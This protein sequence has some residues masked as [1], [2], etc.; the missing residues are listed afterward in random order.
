MCVWNC[1]KNYLKMS[2]KTIQFDPQNSFILRI[3]EKI[4]LYLSPVTL[5]VVIVLIT[6]IV[7]YN[8]RRARMVKLINKIPGPPSLP[9]VGKYRKKCGENYCEFFC[10]E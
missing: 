7:N 4:F 9:L 3:F 5:A 6:W 1:D 2:A 10:L 8:R